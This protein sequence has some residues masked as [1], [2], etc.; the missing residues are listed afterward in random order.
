[1]RQECSKS[2]P[3][4]S[5]SLRSTQRMERKGGEG[6]WSTINEDLLFL[7]RSLMMEIGSISL[8]FVESV[9]EHFLSFYYL[10]QI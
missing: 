8:Q 5:L 2:Y 7:L 6:N 10:Q 3:F 1:M 9:D 4:L